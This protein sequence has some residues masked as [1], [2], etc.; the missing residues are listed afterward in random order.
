[1]TKKR[2]K[3]FAVGGSTALVLLLAMPSQGSAAV[4]SFTFTSGNTADAAGTFTTGAAG[5]DAGYNLLTN[6]TFTALRDQFGTLDIGMLSTSEFE[7]GAEYNLSTGAFANNSNGNMYND[8]GGFELSGM[9]EPNNFSSSQLEYGFRQAG[10]ANSFFLLSKDDSLSATF[11]GDILL[12]TPPPGVS[13]VPEPS[14]WAMM[15]LGFGGLGLLGYRK[16]RKSVATP[17]LAA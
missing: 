7:A 1:M 12:I 6:L 5:A 8:S 13:A 9:T 3:Q 16:S 11:D 2:I 10:V 17:M 14:T 4:F 15:L